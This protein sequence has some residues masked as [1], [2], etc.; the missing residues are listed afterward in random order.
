MGSH[1]SFAVHL[2]VDNLVVVRH[3]GRL[4]DGYRGPVP[5]ELVNDGDLLL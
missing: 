4:L 5:F 3:V 1:F 2:V